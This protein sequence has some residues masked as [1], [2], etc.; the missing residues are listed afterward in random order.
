MYPC[1]LPL[2]LVTR[3]TPKS[4]RKSGGW[5]ILVAVWSL[6]CFHVKPGYGAFFMTAYLLGRPVWDPLIWT[7]FLSKFMSTCPSFPC[8]FFLHSRRGS[9][10]A[11]YINAGRV[12]KFIFLCHS[13][14]IKIQI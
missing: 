13:T 8:L 5:Q 11:S 1:H 9:H 14:V 10:H 7:S 12:A 3:K 2:S 6:S 4:G